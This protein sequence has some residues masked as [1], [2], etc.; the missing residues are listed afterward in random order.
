ML[1]AGSLQPEI[2]LRPESLTLG[3]VYNTRFAD[4][5]PAEARRSG[6]FV[7]WLGMMDEQALAAVQADTTGIPTEEWP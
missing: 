4:T 7:S 2:R 3:F 5:F 6:L 1:R